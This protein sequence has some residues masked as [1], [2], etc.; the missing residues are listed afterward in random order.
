[1]LR[2]YGQ[3][4]EEGIN[5]M[6][7]EVVLAEAV[8]ARNAVLTVNGSTPYNAVY[9]RVPRIL[10]GIDQIDG[11]PGKQLAE[12]QAKK[13]TRSALCKQQANNVQDAV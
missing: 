8:F 6:P 2:A 10:P 12:Q 5:D 13:Q 9:R 1:M 4:K 7:F 3:L 11:P